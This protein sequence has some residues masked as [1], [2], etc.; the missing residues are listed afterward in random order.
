[1]AV[2]LMLIDSVVAKLRY[3]VIYL[4]V[5]LIEKEY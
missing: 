2:K 5:K 1:M 4:E 3:M